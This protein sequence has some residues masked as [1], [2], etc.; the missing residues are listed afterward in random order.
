VVERDAWRVEPAD[1][2]AARGDAV[3]LPCA[4]GPV[5]VHVD[6]VVAGRKQRIDDHGTAVAAC[7]DVPDPRAHAARA[8]VIDPLTVAGRKRETADA[9]HARA[10]GAMECVGAITQVVDAVDEAAGVSLG[11]GDVNVT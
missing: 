11:V 9:G 5:G 4:P 2:P 8:R 1:A 3:M 7:G 6:A 10:V